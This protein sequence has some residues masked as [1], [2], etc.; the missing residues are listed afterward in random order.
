M[1]CGCGGNRSANAVRSVI[2][3]QNIK[4]CNKCGS[5]MIYKQQFNPKFRGYIKLWECPNK[6]CKNTMQS[7]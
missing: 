6:Q 5:R 3:S 7:R 4:T 2:V 1:G